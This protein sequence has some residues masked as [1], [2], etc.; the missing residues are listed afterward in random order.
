VF[1]AS[2]ASGTGQH[3]HAIVTVELV[4]WY[5]VILCKWKLCA[6]T[7]FIRHFMVLVQSDQKIYVH[8]TITVQK[9]PKNT[10]F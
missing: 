5:C 4:G 7:Y 2:Y 3:A 9:T 10:V 8:L 6:Y 1:Y